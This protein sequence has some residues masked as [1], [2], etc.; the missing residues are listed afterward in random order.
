[1]APEQAWNARRADARSDLYS[2]GCT[3]YYLLSGTPPVHGDLQPEK[4]EGH[5]LEV[6]PALQRQR[7]DLPVAVAEI[8][9]KL[10]AADP[11]KRYPSARTLIEALDA[12][13]S[14]PAPEVRFAGA[15]KLRPLKWLVMF[16]VGRSRGYKPEGRAKVV[17]APSLAPQACIP[18]SLASP[19]ALKKKVVPGLLAG[20]LFVAILALV[21]YF[22]YYRSAHLERDQRSRPTP[23]AASAFKGWIDVRIWQP[24]NEQRR[25]LRL[26]HPGTLPLQAKDQIRIEAGLNRTAYLYVLW[27]DPNGKVEPV[28]P[29]R[30]GHWDQRPAAEEPTDRLSLPE[31]PDEGW[32]IQQ[33]IAGME[34][35][36]MLARQT[37]LPP[38]VKLRA[39]LAGFPRQT[40]QDARA[41]VW[42]ENG[43][44][45]QDY[46]ERGPNFFRVERINDPV[47]VTERLF[48]E[49]L[50]PYCD[51]SCAVSFANC[52]Q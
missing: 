26:R 50:Q 40:Q 49:L 45:V 5:A 30:P 13:V 8:I 52:G 33:G 29:W 51:Y 27:V 34:T 38:E 25:G 46:K 31:K 44:V 41:V 16:G 9:R 37:P 48:R 3:F 36:V 18:G 10:L 23:A 15:I 4:P 21:P 28:Y 14:S 43:E 11:D 47:L 19:N 42:F 2:L 12:A 24:G 7:P 22:A 6:L 32:P 39:L 20:L 17:A 1:M 35:L